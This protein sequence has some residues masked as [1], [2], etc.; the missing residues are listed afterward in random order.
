MTGPREPCVQAAIAPSLL[1]LVLLFAM[2]KA[3]T[4]DDCLSAF[5]LG[6]ETSMQQ[7]WATYRAGK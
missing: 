3:Y 6:Q 2:S 7:H 4:D 5:T 1:L